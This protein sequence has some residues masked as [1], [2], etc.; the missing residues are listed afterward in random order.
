M[1]PHH[2]ENSMCKKIKCDSFLNVII[3]LKYHN[4]DC[5]N[6]LNYLISFNLRDKAK[7]NT[8]KIL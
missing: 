6:K 7:S 8:D 2:I 3:I 1:I 5:A 4:F